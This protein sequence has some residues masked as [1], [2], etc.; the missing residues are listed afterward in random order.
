M[1]EWLFWASA[2]AAGI[3]VGQRT[4]RVLSLVAM[5]MRDRIYY[6]RRGKPDELQNFWEWWLDRD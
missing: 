4:S 3:A 5:W 6:T 2:I 1:S